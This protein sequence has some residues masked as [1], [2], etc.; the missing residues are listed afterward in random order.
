MRMTHIPAPHLRVAFT[1]AV[2]AAAT[3]ACDR[4][5]GDS[6]IAGGSAAGRRPASEQLAAATGLSH[7]P[8]PENGPA[9]TAAIRRHYPPR[10]LRERRGGDVLVDVRLDASGR[11]LG[12]TA[13]DNRAALGNP[14]GETRMV[15]ID[16]APGSDLEVQREVQLNYDPQRFGAAAEAAV[17]EVRFR[18]AMR[19]GKPVPYTLRMTVR[20]SPSDAL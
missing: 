3:V 12:A 5:G 6:P 14:G 2:L 18:P 16:K 7:M 17:R 11:V 15:V 8:V 4:G 13:V 19:D 20:F 10:M 1:A 9:F